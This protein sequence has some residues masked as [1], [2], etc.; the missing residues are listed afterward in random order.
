MKYEVISVAV[1]KAEKV[2]RSV[3][4]MDM[5]EDEYLYFESR[6]QSYKH[7]TGLKEAQLIRDQLLAACSDDLSRDMFKLAASSLQQSTDDQLLRRI[8]ELA[9]RPQN[10]L[11]NVVKL[12]Q[13]AQEREEPVK[14]FLVRLKEAANVW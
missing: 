5:G 4:K 9:V 14:N 7:A 13:L 10:N 12:L 1:S 8:K 3:L 6:W 2:P 11:I